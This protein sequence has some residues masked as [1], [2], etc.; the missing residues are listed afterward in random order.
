MS[1]CRAAAE[2]VNLANGTK[3]PKACVDAL[4]EF[5]RVWPG[6]TFPTARAAIVA[7]VLKAAKRAEVRR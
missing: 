3:V 5:E 1:G 7:E 2:W 6:A 4:D